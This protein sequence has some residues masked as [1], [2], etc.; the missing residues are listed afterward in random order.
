VFALYP[1]GAS[2]GAPTNVVSFTNTRLPSSQFARAPMLT[3]E[4]QSHYIDH[5]DALQTLQDGGST[6]EQV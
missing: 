6:C 3:E 5:T 1:Y 2:N 4:S